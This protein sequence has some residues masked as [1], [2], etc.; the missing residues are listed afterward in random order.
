M[1]RKIQRTTSLKQMWI[2]WHKL[3]TALFIVILTV[4]LAV[5][6][7]GYIFDW[8]WAGFGAY[9]S[10][11]HIVKTD[12]QREKTLWD[13]M[14]LLIIPVVLALGGL[15]FNLQQ[16]RTE[17]EIAADHQREDI[18][19]AYLDRMSSLLLDYQL[20]DSHPGSQIREVAHVRTLTVLRKLDPVRKAAL[21]MFLQDSGLIFGEK[22]ILILD[23]ADLTKATLFKA[24]LHGAN[25]SRANMSYVDLREAELSLAT[26]QET[27]LAGAD[28]RGAN[29]VGADLRK[30]D[31]HGANLIGADLREANLDETNLQDTKVAKDQLMK[32]GSHKDANGLNDSMWL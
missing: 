12:F 17:R 2:R 3:R 25:I 13:W 23:G 19:E 1:E 27:N 26:M 8:A 30:A 22:A 21:L 5:I 24:R 10:P 20:R 14:Q 6:I 4:L 18:L 16:S 29:L 31:L 11:P 32:A 15:W 28:L 9:T 7:G